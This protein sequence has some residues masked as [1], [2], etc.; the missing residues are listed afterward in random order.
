MEDPTF[1]PCTNSLSEGKKTN[2]PYYIYLYIIYVLVADDAI[3]SDNEKFKTFT[4][5]LT[6]YDELS[7]M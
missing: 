4:Q 2:V 5:N 1:K 3:Y 6:V 7:G